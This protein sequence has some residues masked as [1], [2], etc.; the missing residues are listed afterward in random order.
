[1]IAIQYHIFYYGERK[2]TAIIPTGNGKSNIQPFS[3]DQWKAECGGIPVAKSEKGHI[4]NYV[5]NSNQNNYSR[6][7]TENH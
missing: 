3:E 2:T 1:L 6:T 4:R 5:R 7:K